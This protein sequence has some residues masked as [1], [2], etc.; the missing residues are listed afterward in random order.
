MHQLEPMKAFVDGAKLELQL[1]HVVGF[2]SSSPK[3]IS[4]RRRDL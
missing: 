1:E 4:S 2:L 3:G